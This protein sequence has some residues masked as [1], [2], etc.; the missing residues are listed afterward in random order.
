MKP[1]EFAIELINRSVECNEKKYAQIE[2]NFHSYIDDDKENDLSRC[3]VGVQ[4]YLGGLDCANE[5]NA[6]KEYQ[7]DYYLQGHERTD[8]EQILK[9]IDDLILGWIGG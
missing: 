4:V 9:E 3:S 6:D 8:Y 7:W 1:Q 2:V 5:R